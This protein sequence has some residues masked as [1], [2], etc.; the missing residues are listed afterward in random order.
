MPKNIFITSK[1]MGK[2]CQKILSK[3]VWFLYPDLK[4]FIALEIC[5]NINPFFETIFPGGKSLVTFCSIVGTM[6]HYGSVGKP[7]LL[8]L[9]CSGCCLA[10][11]RVPRK[12]IPFVKVHAQ[13]QWFFSHDFSQSSSC[14]LPSLDFAGFHVYFYYFIKFHGLWNMYEPFVDTATFMHN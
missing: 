11:Q 9:F 1:S 14:L 12:Y 2:P 6:R 8:T 5:E 3:V 7:Y 13:S 10:G 4:L